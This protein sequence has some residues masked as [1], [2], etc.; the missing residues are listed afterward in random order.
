[1]ERGLQPDRKR[2]RPNTSHQW[3]RR[4]PRSTL[5]PYTTLFRSRRRL[6]PSP[7]KLVR[8]AFSERDPRG[9]EYGTRSA[10]RSEEDTAEHQSPVDPPPA[11][12][13][14]LSVHDAL[15]ISSPLD[16]LPIEVG[17]CSV[18]G[19]RPARHRVWTEV[20]S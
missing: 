16:A 12:I 4:P 14:T 9:I 20:C 18:L 8:A 1:M 17:A 15:P 10:A 2:T 5:F 3:I 7:L 13:Y 19:A 11:E 6:M